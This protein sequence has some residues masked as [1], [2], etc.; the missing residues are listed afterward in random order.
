MAEIV[1]LNRFRKAKA[2]AEA[3]RTAE[4]NRARFGRT[5]AEKEA[6]KAAEERA[7]R[8]L[9]GKKLDANKLDE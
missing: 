2:K 5:K 7:E 1:N 9:D 6:V 3:R 4:A 8:Q